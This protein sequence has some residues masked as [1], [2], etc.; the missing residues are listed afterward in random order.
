MS[1]CTLDINGRKVWLLENGDGAPLLYLHG[2]ADVHS[3]KESWLPFHEELAKS[4]RVIARPIPAAPRA[5]RT[6]TLT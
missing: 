4:S 6:K 1:G 2:F 3:V 5:T